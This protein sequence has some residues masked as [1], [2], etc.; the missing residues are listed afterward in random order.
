MTMLPAPSPYLGTVSVPQS[1]NINLLSDLA[2]VIPILP[3][4]AKMSVHKE[5]M[6][7]RNKTMFHSITFYII[8]DASDNPCNENDILTYDKKDARHAWGKKAREPLN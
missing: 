5:Q 7:Q 8:L 6:T 1:W 4:L 2:Q 3:S